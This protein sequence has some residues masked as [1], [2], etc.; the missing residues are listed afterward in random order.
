MA[1]TEEEARARF[2]AGRGNV[3]VDRTSRTVGEIF[4]ANV[5]TRFNALLGSLLVVIL[6]V[7]PPQDSL[8]GLVL[9]GNTAVGVFQELRAKRTLDR[10]T[11]VGGATTT[12]VRAE[13]ARQVP[14]RE[15]VEG[16]TIAIGRGDQIVVDGVVLAS[17]GLEVDESLL[18]GEAEPEA[19]P[20]GSMLLSGSWV[21]AGSGRQLAEVVGEAAYGRRLAVEGRRFAL[22]RSEL[23][24]GI[25]VILRGV[26]WVL[27]PTAVLLFVSQVAE[28]SD[29]SE[30]LR[31][32]VA[33]VVNM[34]PEG[35]VLLTSTAL[36]VGIVRLGRQR[37]LVGELGALEGLARV[38][39]LCLDKTGTL[40]DGQPEL[41]AIEP[42]T[43]G[44]DIDLALGGFAASDPDPNASLLAIRRAR[45]GSEW[46]VTW[47]V[48][49]SSAQRWSAVGLADGGWAL[50]APD[51]LLEWV[52][53]SYREVVPYTA[54][55][56]EY[57]CR[58]RSAGVAVRLVPGKHR[59]RHAPTGS[60]SRWPSSRWASRCA[61][62]CARPCRGSR[63]K[64]SR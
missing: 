35:L 32:S 41:A 48:A 59:Q 8:F 3:V 49:F 14:S 25:D 56:G 29:L 19:K 64:G 62:T 47:R 12:V 15:V 53:P 39:V 28:A 23:R 13:G 34:V 43:D 61:M 20:V 57:A 60:S 38:D 45:P 24:H 44:I 10:L 58:R 37:V 17:D 9:I 7:G 22:A 21:V 51:V 36:A 54:R 30:A 26:T 52:A 2:A 33:G 5:L 31:V 16:D 55:A 42:L 40:T 50:G 11:V 1:L 18:T 4:R 46:P 63:R 6:I 27:V